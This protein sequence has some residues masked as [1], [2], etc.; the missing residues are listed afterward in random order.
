MNESTTKTAEGALNQ[1]AGTSR[2]VRGQLVH[3]QLERLRNGSG[4]GKSS[5]QR[6]ALRLLAGFFVFMLIFTVLSRAAD[7]L[8]VARVETAVVG[9]GTL[10]HGINTNG[11]VRSSN[12]RVLSIPSGLEIERMLA[13]AGSSVRTGDTLASFDPTAAERALKQRRNEL[14]SLRLQQDMERAD[15]S[16]LLTAQRALASAK[17][18]DAM[19]RSESAEA[20][21]RAEREMA[22]ANEAYQ[23]LYLEHQYLVGEEYANWMEAPKWEPDDIE[24]LRSSS[25]DTEEQAAWKSSVKAARSELDAARRTSE[26][27]EREL[28]SAIRANEKTILSGERSIAAAQLA[29][30]DAM[31]NADEASRS[32]AIKREGLSLDIAKKQEE[33]AALEQIISNEC[34]L[35]SPVDGSILSAK[36]EDGGTSMEGDSVVLLPS[37]EDCEVRAL[38]S[39]DQVRWI[40]QGDSVRV[41][42]M[43]GGRQSTVEG[44]VASIGVAEDDKYELTI[45]LPAGSYL[46]GESAEIDFSRQS[47]VQQ[48]VLPISA[49]HTDSGE[50]NFIYV[51]SAGDGILGQEYRAKRVNVKVLDRDSKNMA[52][53][54]PL[55]AD[56]PVIVGSNRELK[57]GDRVRLGVKQ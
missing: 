15:E 4:K 7:S 3:G 41:T 17:E 40:A 36:G 33:I 56:D 8:T 54:A 48:M 51:A 5:Q 57:D 42:L 37:G 30:D 9:S 16:P 25:T 20:V 10:D 43:Q 23:K 18:D 11:E 46:S 50:Q 39:K 47:E 13:K 53:E 52:V 14:K 31:R 45:A 34:S 32:A 35:L 22:L 21:K 28:Q 49:L 19:A 29:Y 44:K 38:I 26:S 24:D 12:Q 2:L 1:K 55:A 6:T 27:C